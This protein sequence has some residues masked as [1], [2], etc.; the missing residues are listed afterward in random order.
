MKTVCVPDEG[1][2]EL[3][4]PSHYRIPSYYSDDVQSVLVPAGLEKDVVDKIAETVRSD[5][6]DDTIHLLCVLKGARTFYTELL[7]ALTDIHHK[8][9]Y[10]RM[11]YV[12]H[13]I[14]I[15]SYI[16]SE[17]AGPVVVHP[18]QLTSLVGQNVLVVE[19][20][21]DTGKTLS[22]LVSAI[23][24]VGAKSVRVAVLAEKRTSRRTEQFKADYTGFSLPD[25][26][27]I[28]HGFDYNQ[29][30]RDLPHICSIAPSA[31]AKYSIKG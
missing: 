20:I 19:D 17:S 10:T 5:Y 23:K 21:L 11:P 14:Q 9:C 15:K 7:S 16:D 27:I 30:F 29:N 28:G 3:S 31:I 24:E 22:A 2:P 13:F 6:G 8:G 25:K 26:F 18:S 4:D 12:E 1:W